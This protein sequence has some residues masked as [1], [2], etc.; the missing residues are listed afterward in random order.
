MI[1]VEGHDDAQYAIVDLVDPDGKEL[2][3][4]RGPGFGGL[5]DSAN[6]PSVGEG[7]GSVM[8][9]MAPGV[10]ATPGRWRFRFRARDLDSREPDRQP[11]RVQ[12]I[13]TEKHGQ[14]RPKL[15]LHVH[16]SGKPR[17]MIGADGKQ[18]SWE[19]WSAA[20]IKG[21][22]SES[23][24]SAMLRVKQVFAEAG[25]DVV[26]DEDVHQL[27]RQL[28]VVDSLVGEG[29]ELRVLFDAGQSDK[30]GLNLFFVS[31]LQA[32]VSSGLYAGGVSPAIGVPPALPS[33]R[34]LGVAVTVNSGAVVGN[35][36]VHEVAHYL[37]L[38]HTIEIDRK[39][40]DPIPDTPAAGS[41][42]NVMYPRQ[43]SRR[44]VFSPQQA[45]VLRGSPL[46]EW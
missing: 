45:E 29:N 41:K 43:T 31:A 23:Y 13:R 35:T 36:V 22:E 42:D 37:G 15:R 46:L 27:D 33:G 38:H 26:I 14:E 16:T 11:G 21:G 20:K 34:R 39:T 24:E 8:V 5:R 32:G 4:A 25:I 2:V 6:P 18:H 17:K 30:P 1:T 3:R 40:V 12:V 19:Q 10:R 7:F 28:N 9:P 44:Q